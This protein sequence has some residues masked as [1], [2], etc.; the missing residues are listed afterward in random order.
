[1]TN[2]FKD[3]M[4]PRELRLGSQLARAAGG[5]PHIAGNRAVFRAESNSRLADRSVSGVGDSCH[6][7]ARTWMAAP[8][9]KQLL[10]ACIPNSSNSH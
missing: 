8:S 10:N 5:G 6:W 9:L 4:A 1:M 2:P 3:R 7:A